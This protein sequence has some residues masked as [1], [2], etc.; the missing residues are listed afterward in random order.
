MAQVAVTIA[1]STYRID[2]DDGDEPRLAALAEVVDSQVEGMR[3]RF[4]EIG[5]RRLLIMAA[6]SIADELVDT[7][8]HVRDLEAAADRQSSRADRTIAGIEDAA[9]LIERIAGELNGTQSR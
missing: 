7:T 5:D 2:C 9:A 6:I 3:A 4:G 8:R 1:G